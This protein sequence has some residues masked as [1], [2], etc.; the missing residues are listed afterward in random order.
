MSGCRFVQQG[1]AVTVS[2]LFAV[3]LPAAAQQVEWRQDY[4][5][6]RAEARTSGRPLVLDFS[7]E[8]CMWCRKLEATTFRDPAVAA[9]LARDFVPLHVDALRQ[10]ALARALKIDRYPTLLF[11]APDGTIL[12]R[13]VGFVDA[14]RF[15]GQLERALAR[16]PAKAPA[17]EIEHAYREAG[18]AI[19]TRD[20]PRA[21]ALL[22][23]VAADGRDGPAERKAG[24][25]LQDFERAAAE[26]LRQAQQLQ[27]EEARAALAN[28]V[29]TFDGT[30]AARE[31]TQTLT[32]RVR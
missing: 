27:P 29:R 32:A 5:K 14:G 9:L 25:L 31:A 13:H 17:A 19:Q 15:R 4:A 8:Q 21:I 28:L 18:A 2:V 30:A 10:P 23:Q 24:A 12:G 6:A 20:Y 1:W 26:Q 11:A 7:T 22:R 16:V 3:A